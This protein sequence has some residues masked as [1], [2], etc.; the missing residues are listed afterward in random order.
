MSINWLAHS[1]T[2]SAQLPCKMVWTCARCWQ[3]WAML[4]WN[5]LEYMTMQYCTKTTRTATTP[6]STP[7]CWHSSLSAVQ[8]LFPGKRGGIPDR[9]RAKARTKRPTNIP[10]SELMHG[11]HGVKGSQCMTFLVN[12]QNA[13]H[14][15]TNKLWTAVCTER[16][17]LSLAKLPIPSCLWRISSFLR[18]G[19]FEPVCVITCIFSKLIRTQTDSKGRPWHRFCAS[20]HLSSAQSSCF[21]LLRKKLPALCLVPR[22]YQL[23]SANASDAKH[24]CRSAW[25]WV[26][27][28]RWPSGMKKTCKYLIS[29]SYKWTTLGDD[30]IRNLRF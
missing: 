27:E 24:G 18:A 7:V 25:T 26:Q 22:R 4:S 3:G 23:P 12:A 9:K 19:T 8:T 28:L 14:R 11:M 1:G 30:E 16:L 29:A 20:L 15:C 13:A 17:W 21:D 6:Y 10:C 5:M 2:T